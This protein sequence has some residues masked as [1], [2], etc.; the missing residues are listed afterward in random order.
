[1]NL[2][3]PSLI[4]LSKQYQKRKGRLLYFLIFLG[5]VILGLIY[6]GLFKFLDFVYQA[7]MLGSVMGPIIGK[8]IASKLLEMIIL[9]L[10]FMLF[11][12][13]TIAS[14]SVF[15]LDDE[16]NLLFVSP[17]TTVRIFWS[18][19]V[20]MII[21]SSWMAIIAFLPIFY[22]FITAAKSPYQAYLFFPLLL[23]LYLMGPNI[24]GALTALLL[25]TFFPIRQ[26]KK[27][28]Q[29]LSA[30]VLAAMVFFFRFL[31]PEKLLNPKYFTTVSNYILMLKTSFLES[32]PSSWMKNASVHLFN[33]S[34]EEAIYAA[35]PLLGFTV[36]TFLILSFLAN[37][38]YRL[39]W[40]KSLEAVENQVLGLEFGRKLLVAP[41][42]LFPD[43]IRVVLTKEITIFFRDP[44]IFAQLF[45]MAAI[46]FV[47]GYNLYIMPLKDLPALYSGETFD[48]MVYF[49]G[50]FIGFIIAAMSMRFVFP[51]ISLE[52]RA[53]WAVKASP[54]APSRLLMMK[55]FLYL[56][57]NFF[58]SWVLCGISN[59][60]FQ[61]SNPI[62]RYLSFINVTLMAIVATALSI[63][64]GAIY[65]RF[66]AENPLKIA[67]SF[68]GVVYMLMNGLFIFNLLLCQVYP[69]YR[70]FFFRFIPFYDLKGKILVTLCFIVLF[71][72][73]GFWTYIPLK[74]GKEA[75]EKY[76]PD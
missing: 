24:L 65:A 39:S 9:S 56:W 27:I 49:N 42:K 54:L 29:F 45:M 50:P 72:C 1:M 70:Y 62:L 8:L 26:M 22:A 7:P 23:I 19:F 52:G 67:G 3:K 25:G 10:F 32:F 48:S 15:Y 30:I 71:I 64:I 61:V 47:Y 63:G 2:L 12:S 36:G 18:R 51:S 20:L 5:L 73:T 69:M 55:F 46:M 14:F 58:F 59:A 60:L 74:K 75:L 76:E 16:L 34:F 53:F 4:K 40:Q 57:P 31:E 35:L 17:V 11:F 6:F 21:E 43:D 44:A 66:D 41:F 68:G 38:F 28:F 33:G 37:T 13:S